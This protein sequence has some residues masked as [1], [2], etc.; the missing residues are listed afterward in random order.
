[1]ILRKLLAGVLVG[2]AAW[3]VASLTN[4]GGTGEGTEQVFVAASDLPAGHH[5]T[6]ADTE[7]VAVPAQLIPA[8]ARSVGQE[9]LDEGR[10]L[11]AAVGAGEMITGTRLRSPDTFDN[12]GADRRAL[13]IPLSDTGAASLLR[14]GT[15]VD[16]HSA[17]DGKVIAADVPVLQVDLVG[18]EFDSGGQPAVILDV[19]AS[20]APT[21][22]TAM[23]S[24]SDSG[25]GVALAVRGD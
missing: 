1:M 17:F 16:V 4:L 18:E 20:A 10:V 7:R 21:L 15:R 25:A 23:S 19:P 12:L 9:T 13:R 3:I 6:T 24:A 22:T 14:P 11:T 8:S 5:L 2:V